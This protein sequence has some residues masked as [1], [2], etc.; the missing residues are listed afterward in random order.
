MSCIPQRC[1]CAVHDQ[2]LLEVGAS[3]V[4]SLCV[5]DAQNAAGFALAVGHWLK[6]HQGRPKHIVV[7]VVFCGVV[8]AFPGS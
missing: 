2:G 5:Q 4:N 7:C 8:S 3:K 6:L 1:V